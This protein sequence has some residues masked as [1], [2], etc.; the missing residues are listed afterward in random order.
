M[1]LRPW[2]LIAGLVLAG[3]AAGQS[4]PR[5]QQAVTEAACRQRAERI[6]QMRH[7]ETD[8]REDTYTSS[9]R[10]AP[11]GTSGTPSLPTRGLSGAYE[12]QQLIDECLRSSGPVGP[13]PA[14]PPLA[15]P[16]PTP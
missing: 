15:A 7:P 2:P 16:S 8:Y 14:T 9:L 1:T 3:C 12:L 10:D 4:S 11:F 13:T 5:G 6:Y